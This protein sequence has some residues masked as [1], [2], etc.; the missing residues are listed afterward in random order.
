MVPGPSR[1]LQ[2]LPKP[3][4]PS[5]N[6]GKKNP[7]KIRIVFPIFPLKGPYRLGCGLCCAVGLISGFSVGG[8]VSSNLIVEV[9]GGPHEVFRPWEG[10]LKGPFKSKN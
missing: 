7:E 6:P 9:R 10:A 8:T 5:K 3:Q 1:T 2:N 4:K